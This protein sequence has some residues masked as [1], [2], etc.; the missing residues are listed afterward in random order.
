MLLAVV[1]AALAGGIRPAAAATVIGFLAADFFLTV[2][3][4]SLRVDRAIDVA[5]LI[6]F[7]RVAA[8]TGLLVDILARRGIQTAGVPRAFRIRIH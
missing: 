4:G 1:L 3:Y 7:A 2:P 5:G 6:V 8:A